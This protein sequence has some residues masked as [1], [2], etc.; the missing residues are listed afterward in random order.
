[1]DDLEKIVELDLNT[2]MF[3]SSF[4]EWFLLNENMTASQFLKQPANLEYAKSI[5][6]LVIG[7]VQSRI[8]NFNQGTLS[9]LVNW[10]IKELIIQ[11]IDPSRTEPVLDN[12]WDN[13]GDFIA[14]N[15]NVNQLSSKLNSVDY[16]YQHAIND[17]EQWHEMLAKKQGGKGAPGRTVIN[18][19]DV[20]GFKGW[21][22]V[23]MDKAGCRDEGK[24]MGH[25]GNTASPSVNDNLL[26]LRDPEGYPHLTF[27]N[28]HGILGETKGRGNSKPTLKYHPAIVKLLLSN[29]IGAIKG[30]GY[31]PENN[32]E[33][34]DLTPDLQKIVK[35]KKPFIDDP[36][37]FANKRERVVSGLYK[38][39]QSKTIQSSTPETVGSILPEIIYKKLKPTDRMYDMDPSKKITDQVLNNILWKFYTE[40]LNETYIRSRKELPE[41][42]FLWMDKAI[43]SFV[44]TLFSADENRF[45]QLEK[46]GG[47]GFFSSLSN[48]YR[49]HEL[50]EKLSHEQPEIMDNAP[51]R[52]EFSSFAQYKNHLKHYL[53]QEGYDL[54][55]WRPE[56]NMLSY[57]FN[58]K[59]MNEITKQGK[60][61]QDM[62]DQSHE[63]RNKSMNS[64]K[65]KYPDSKI[66]V[67]PRDIDD[68]RRGGYQGNIRPGH[69]NHDI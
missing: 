16:R 8:H 69:Y 56:N 51:K 35:D 66:S 42:L 21:T 63:A 9:R 11:K 38:K 44:N 53:D 24:A 12:M 55:G 52:F 41:N 20:P 68:A 15:L 13:I 23:A 57:E 48:I 65:T 29:E 26:S 50:A 33:F 47:L 37:R 25:C 18:L 67:T 54:P 40:L 61:I 45:Q 34:T 1:M 58:V 49:I 32:F 46:T 7:F 6:N 28:N 3:R 31:A 10:L 36:Y 39:V 27:I 14:A 4:S 59:I 19:D 22:W 17:S 2:F 64:L 62:L 60:K 5:K 43:E 30:G